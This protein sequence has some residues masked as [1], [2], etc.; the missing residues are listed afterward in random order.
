MVPMK[1]LQRAIKAAGGRRALAEAC[2]VKYQ[3]VQKWER[4]TI[5]AERVLQVEK[6]T[7]I[8]RTRLRPDLYPKEG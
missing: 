6:A 8:H 3:A 5:P 1:A 4:G 7:S 2:G